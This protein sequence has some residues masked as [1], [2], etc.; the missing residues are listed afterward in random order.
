MIVQTLVSASDAAATPATPDAVPGSGGWKWIDVELDENT[1]RNE[2][3]SLLE[4]LD[5]DVL[6]VDDAFAD[7]DLPKVDDFGDHLLVVLH[8]LSDSR[9]DTYELD[10]FLTGDSLITV[11]R[12]PSPSLSLYFAQVQ[13]S[14]GLAAGTAAD[15]LAR[16]A[17][18]ATRRYLVFLD[19]VDRRL[20][21]LTELAL[22]ANPHFLEHLTEFRREVGQ[23]RPIL[24]PQREVF[25]QLTRSAS[26]LVNESARRRFSDVYDVAERSVLEYEAARSA[27]N[28][29]LGA[30]QG[31]EAREAT[32][33]TKVL[34]IYAAVML[35]LSLI[36]GFFGMNFTGLPGADDDAGWIWSLALMGGVAV[37]SLAVFVVIGWLRPASPR[38]TVRAVR[39]GMLDAVRAPVQITGGLYRD[40]VKPL[41]RRVR[42]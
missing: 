2:L 26:P 18:V 6:A 23:I 15:L 40:T 4:G 25:D 31:A 1:S 3:D 22:D 32:A 10:C 39:R 20:D 35:P 9:V 37:A 24:R 19:H 7:F 17:D 34:T 12:G 41:R 33:I 42:G 16:L 38:Q 14:A 30:Y 13:R 29:A 5:L 11:H 28:D 21:D 27:M 8:G 36:A